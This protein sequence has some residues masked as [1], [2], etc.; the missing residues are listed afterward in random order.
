MAISVTWGTKVINV[1]K[2]Y[3]TLVQ[4]SPTEIRDLDTNQFR[5][6]LKS[7]EDDVYGMAHDTTHVHNPPLSVG[8]IELARTIEIIND[9]TI[10][11]E[12]G[13]WAVNLK[14]SNNNILDRT[15]KNQVSVNP[16]NSAGLVTSSAIEFGEYGGH[17]TVDM[18]NQS[19]KAG[20]GTVYPWGTLRL[21]VNNFADAEIIAASRGFSEMYLISDATVT[22]GDNIENMIIH[23][24]NP[25]QTTFTVLTGASTINCEIH[26]CTI[27]GVLDGG[28]HLWD[29]TVGALNYVNGQMHHCMINGP[30]MLGGNAVAHIHGC[31]SGVPELGVPEVNMGGSGQALALRDYH[32]GVE[33]TNKTGTDSVSIDLSSGQIIL[34]DTVTAGTFR[35]SGVGILH[36]NSTGCTINSAG[37]LS[38]YSVTTTTWKSVYIDVNNGI[39]GT[40]FPLGTTGNPVLTLA[41]AE[42]IGNSENIQSFQVAGDLTLDRDV[43]GYEFTSWKNGK[44]TMGNQLCTATRFRELK[45]DGTMNGLGLLYDCRI[46]NLQ[47]IQGIFTNCRFLATNDILISSSSVELIKCE[48]E[49]SEIQNFDWTNGGSLHTKSLQGKYTFKNC[50]SADSVNTIICNMA[51]ITLDATLTSGT[52]IMSGN[53]RYTDNSN[54][55]IVIDSSLTSLT[56]KKTW[57]SNLSSYT[58]HGTAGE[59]LHHTEY[60]DKAIYVDTES[61]TNGNGV[62]GNPYDNIG[63]AIDAAE[64]HGF[65][66]IIVY[67]EITLDR[68]LKNFNL[69][70]VGT[71]VIECGGHNLDKSEVTQCELR[72]AYTGIIAVRKCVLG[73]GLELNGYFENCG[74]SGNLT[75][76]VGS[77][78]ILKDCVS[79]IQN[80]TIDQD[81]G[82]ASVINLTDFAGNLTITN[83][84]TAG[85]VTYIGMREG[86]VTLA[87]S[88]TAGFIAVGGKATVIDNSAGSTVNLTGL[89][90]NVV[91]DQVWDEQIADHLEAGSTGNKLNTASSGGVDYDSLAVAVWDRNL[92]LH[93]TDGS[94]GKLVKE[95]NDIENGNWEIAGNQMIFKDS[96]GTELFRVNLFDSAGA[97]SMDEVYKRTRV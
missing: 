66:T 96:S 2:D 31:Y 51:D 74:I 89:L 64:D 72:G 73:A 45:L 47:N 78:A 58:T 28:T 69:V 4:V 27:S 65:K 20:S 39:A 13:Q 34:A 95:T 85:D 63:D 90:Q 16:G 48:T 84:G 25:T 82:G 21:P 71:P 23:G 49:G 26:S 17:V 92:S 19:G 6:D 37:L 7:L 41:D 60:I 70:G 52:F 46:E 43:S 11:F 40:E 33:I 94:A 68:N 30:I 3:T 97:P 56:A 61:A 50:S 42:I 44:I 38:T 91:A 54:G 36:D 86:T 9:Y 10:T 88:C 29:C 5:L 62:L 83:C 24:E 75:S 35:I 67:S 18:Q 53:V 15:N 55:A 93:T 57:E 80:V 22:T 59:V 1:P 81:S 14:G 87:A 77:N 76:K 12:D 8:G 32:G 79:L